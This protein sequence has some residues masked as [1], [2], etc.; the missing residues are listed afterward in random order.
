MYDFLIYYTYV[1]DCANFPSAV[2]FSLFMYV[3][4]YIVVWL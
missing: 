3:Y 1:I 4:V 2:L